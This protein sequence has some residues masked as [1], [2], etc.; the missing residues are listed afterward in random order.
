MSHLKIPVHVEVIINDDSQKNSTDIILEITEILQSCQVFYNGLTFDCTDKNDY[1][2]I[3]VCDIADN[4]MISFWQAELCVHA[5]KLSEQ[6]CEKDY[7]EGENDLPACDQWELPNKNLTGYWDSIVVDDHIKNN[8][9]GYCDSSMQFSDANIDSTII[10]W[11]RIALLY[12]PPGSGKIVIYYL[13][14]F[15]V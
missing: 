7:L 2:E 4:K 5:F 9:L 6:E 15:I 13:H 1:I 8:L 12:G 14:I 3:K 10:S 11:N